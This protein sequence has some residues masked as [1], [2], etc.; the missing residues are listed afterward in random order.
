MYK[1]KLYLFGF[2]AASIL[3]MA[4]VGVALSAHITQKNI[5]QSTLAQTL[6]VEHQQLSSTSYRLFKQLTDELIFGKN[7]NQA[8][9]RR[10]QELIKN[11]LDVIRQ[12]EIKQRQA[13]GA[14]TTHGSLEDTDE[15]EALLNDI[16]SEF[17]AII[18]I[19]DTT[20]LNQQVRL[21]R[22]LEV[23]IDNQFRDVINAAVGRQ[24]RMVAATNASI[25]MLN[26]VLLWVAIVSCFLVG[27]FV[28]FGCVWLFNQLYQ[29]LTVIESGTKI[30][31]SGD[32]EF[33]L[34]ENLD[35]EF[36]SLVVSLN[37]L[38][39]RLAEHDNAQE[40]QNKNLQIEVQ[41]RTRELTEANHQ[42][43]L[44]DARRKQFMADISHELR[45]PLTIIRGEA[46]ITLRQTHSDEQ[47][48]RDTLQVIL[49]QSIGLSRLVDDLLL[50]TRAEMNQ[51]RMEFTQFDLQEL[52][53]Q[54]VSYWQRTHPQR[55]IQL[56]CEEQE[57][58]FL[59]EGDEQRIQ[60]VIAILIDNAIKYSSATAP[61]S[62]KI[63]NDRSHYS[64]AV[65]DEGDGMS[66]SELQAVFDRFVRFK[67]KADGMGLGLSIAKAIVTAHHG[68]IRA[69]SSQ[70][71]GSV[72]RIILPKSQT[73]AGIAPIT[74][75]SQHSGQS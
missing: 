46:Q 56:D 74:Q 65:T 61:V 49:D 19:A 30:I 6:L 38:A 66:P 70:R 52:L 36:N 63:E 29:P 42:L 51:L 55:L 40:Q 69:E 44:Q 22:L 43:T 57:T 62:V 8:L 75:I 67:S 47:T 4:L 31:A 7:A 71:V 68:E 5:E 64:I 15:L 50:L 3:V 27:P 45:T 37:Q 11:S 59:I 21:Q 72:F 26:Q 23:T 25:E 34:P 9:V 24:S 13:L 2:I 58:E 39:A 35:K 17:R 54:Q 53:A 73:L 10:K 1:N 32:Y 33:R 12:L 16:V 28:V 18:D 60:Q 41:I 14:E 48:Y 20:P